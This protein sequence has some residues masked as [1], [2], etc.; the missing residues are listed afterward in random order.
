MSDCTYCAFARD[1]GNETFTC[2]MV[3]RPSRPEDHIAASDYLDGKLL[4]CPVGTEGELIGEH[5]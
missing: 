2:D 1:E 3:E 4:S 5:T